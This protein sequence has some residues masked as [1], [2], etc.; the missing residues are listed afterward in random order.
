MAKLRVL[1][2]L[3]EFP[4]AEPAMVMSLAPKLDDLE[5]KVVGFLHHTGSAVGGGLPGADPFLESVKALLEAKYRLAGTV[6]RTKPNLSRLVPRA[7]A[8]ELAD[9]ADVVINGTCS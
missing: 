8:D 4:A 7:M 3:A 2:P 9:K 1:D 5:G 6:W